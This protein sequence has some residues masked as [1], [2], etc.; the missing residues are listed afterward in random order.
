MADDM[1]T[2]A[3]EQPA[4]PRALVAIRQRSRPSLGASIRILVASSSFRL[5][6]VYV[7]LFGASVILLL[8]FIYWSTAVYM[9]SQTD[10]TIDAEVS[11]LAERYRFSG[12]RGL[13]DSIAQRV[14]RNPGGESVYLLADKD[15]KPL[16]G[17]LDRWPDVPQMEN[18]WLDFT[19]TVTNPREGRVEQHRARG[20]HFLLPGG[21]N[22]LVGRDVHS[23]EETKRRIVTT[24]AWGLAMTVVLALAGGAMMSRSI[25]RRIDLIN[26]TSREIMTGDLS[27]RIPR[28][29]SGD[30]FD[31]L[32]ENLNRMLDQIQ[33]L[34]DEVREVS[35]NIAHD[36]RTPL[37]RLR[38]QL[39][40]MRNANHDAELHAQRVDAAIEEADSLLATFNALLRIARVERGDRRAGFA[41][42]DI[43]AVLRDVL[44]FYEP[45]A[46]ERGQ[47][48]TLEPGD[49]P[50]EIVGDRDLLFQACANLVDNAVKYTPEGGTISLS[51]RTRGETV[52]VRV[53]DSGPGV[54]G[55][56]REQIV[57]RFVRLERSRSTPGNGLGLALVAGVARLH[58]GRLRLDDVTPDAGEQRGLLA[59]LELPRPP[60]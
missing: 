27:R 49:T 15:F 46:E 17:N 39:E 36:L 48:L 9:V 35:D 29:G 3:R 58:G 33:S 38:N 30:D 16:I 41:A 6:L 8:G 24:L 11:G 57:K 53:A 56:C 31:Q 55:H 5:A 18:P 22:L 7:V 44:E 60:G 28:T 34:M 23:L 12:V 51:I 1:S 59:I 25:V 47:T 32:A 52:Q 54:P 2:P 26:Q 45:L 37:T 10:E 13:S 4:E 50:V 19:L 42:L 21:Y 40:M 20:R 43:N 14:A